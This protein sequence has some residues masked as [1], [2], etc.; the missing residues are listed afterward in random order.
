[1]GLTRPV[2]ISQIQTALGVSSSVNKL[3]QLCTHANV[4]KWSK[5]KPIKYAANGIMSQ[6]DYTNERWKD[7]ST[8][9]KGSDG[10]MGFTPY[11]TTNFTNI[12]NNTTGGMNGWTYSGTPTG[13][14]YPYRQADFIGY[15]HNAVP[16]A[17]NFMGTTRTKNQGQFS[18]QCDIATNADNVTL[19]DFAQSLYFG[20]AIV[21]GSGN[22]V[23]YGTNGNTWNGAVSFVLRGVNQGTYTVVPFL[24]TQAITPDSGSFPQTY[25]F[26]T[27]PSVNTYSL[28]VVATIASL[29]CI[30]TWVNTQHTRM[31]VSI[32]NN[33]VSSYTGAIYVRYTNHSWTDPDSNT[34]PSSSFT[35]NGNS[36]V[37]RNFTNLSSEHRYHVTIRL[38]NGD[39]FEAGEYSPFDPTL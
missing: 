2:S 15:N 30:Y 6:Y 11:T 16:A 19:Q 4:N 36:S 18:A 28:S 14:T 23:F 8:W 20:A 38:Q 29:T 27:L 12:R 35:V 17:R 33:D 24:C 9:W 3:S 10:N 37:S 39:I 7:D 34:E 32:E 13:G 25:T 26:W 5:Y 31:N 22:V 1:M 21:N